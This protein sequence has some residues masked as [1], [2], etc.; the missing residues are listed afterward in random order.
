MFLVDMYECITSKYKHLIKFLRIA[1]FLAFE[2]QSRPVFIYFVYGFLNK[3]RLTF[4]KFKTI[5]CLQLTTIRSG[6]L[7][8][9]TKRDSSLNDIFVLYFTCNKILDF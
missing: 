9:T 8:V 5:F 1:F 7:I 3:Q 6:S 4:F 2:S